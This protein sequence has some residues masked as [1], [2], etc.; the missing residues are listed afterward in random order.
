MQT[1]TFN[2]YNE[3]NKAVQD[4]YA[5]LTANI[6]LSGPESHYKSL[7][8]T[9][10]KPSV[11]K[12][13]IAISLAITMAGSGWKVLLVDGD[14]RKPVGGKRL[15][16]N[17]LLGLSDYLAGQ[18]DLLDVLCNTNIN[19]LTYLYGGENRQNP[20]GLLCSTRFEELNAW[21]REQ[22]DFVIYDT[23]ALSSVV[24]ASL[25]AARV[26]AT[27]LVVEIGQ[28][29]MDSLKP[30]KE[31]LE[32]VNANIMGVVLNKV[33]KNAYKKY[34]GAFDYFFDGSKFVNRSS[35]DRKK[36]SSS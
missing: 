26:D 35:R 20:I 11:G 23:P 34:F 22:Y 15:G 33:K 6:H 25:I 8:L 29:S 32:K 19:N 27:L 1:K 5:M 21:A 24:D 2:V 31:Q 17:T 18:A 10:C 36:K 12:T 9:S 4:A 14:M 7:A 28:T 16:D 3:E 30:A 13:S